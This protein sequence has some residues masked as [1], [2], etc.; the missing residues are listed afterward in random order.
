MILFTYLLTDKYRVF[1]LG[2]DLNSLLIL[3]LFL[4][5]TFFHAHQKA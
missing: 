5:A 2:T 1:G 4:L 3:L